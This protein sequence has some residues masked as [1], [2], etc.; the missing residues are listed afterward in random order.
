MASSTLGVYK[1]KW[2]DFFWRS[3]G[4]RWGNKCTHAHSIHDYRG[5]RNDPWLL[6]LQGQGHWGQDAVEHW[7]RAAQ[8]LAA[9]APQFP[10]S[11]QH[12]EQ[13]AGAAQN[14]AARASQFPDGAQH[15]EQCADDVQ[16]DW[17]L[18]GDVQSQADIP[19]PW[20]QAGESWQQGGSHRGALQWAG[21]VQSQA[22]T[23]DQ[24]DMVLD[25]Q[26]NRLV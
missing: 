7:A 21:D 20:L 11:A 25:E 9:R 18:T 6:A 14:L 12:I 15:I 22:D 5:A 26:L 24:C 23:P 17:Q 16:T 19:D 2:C 1:K 3:H 8:N 13:R 4:C 10:D